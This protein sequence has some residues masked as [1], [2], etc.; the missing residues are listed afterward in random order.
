MGLVKKHKALRKKLLDYD[1]DIKSLA[2]AAGIAEGTLGD[3]F[4]GEYP[5]DARQM[6][7]VAKVLHIDRSEYHIYFFDYASQKAAPGA[8]TPRTARVV[9]L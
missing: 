3:R 9:H 6:D 4:R 8:G 2:K 5:F 7:A 1:L